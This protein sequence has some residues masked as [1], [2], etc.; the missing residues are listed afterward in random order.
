VALEAWRAAAP[1]QIPAIGRRNDRGKGLR[2]GEAHQGSVS[3]L[4][5]GGGSDGGVAWR[6]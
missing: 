6:R 2:G 3:A 1:A 5:W 4:G